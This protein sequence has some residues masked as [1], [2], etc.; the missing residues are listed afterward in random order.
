MQAI[1]TYAECFMCE[2]PPGS[3]T[4]RFYRSLNKR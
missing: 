1:D 3:G 4:K 2:D